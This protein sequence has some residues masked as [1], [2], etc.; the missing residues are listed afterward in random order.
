LRIPPPTGSGDNPLAALIFDAKYDAYRG[1]V[2]HSRVFEGAVKAG[3]IIRFM[4]NNSTYKVE[5]VGH[6]LLQRAK[7]EKLS[8]GEVGYI[9]A[10]VKTVSDVRDGR[11]DHP[12]G[13]ALPQPLP[14]SRRSKPVVFASIYPIASDDYQDLA[15]SLEKYKL[16]DASFITRKTPLPRWAG[17]SLRLSGASAPGHRSGETGAGI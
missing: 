16:N 12:S 7:R 4:Y 15:D 2:I 3:D 1:T 6:F 8:A 17:I 10:G 11:Y 9:I 14:D 5:E 13:Q